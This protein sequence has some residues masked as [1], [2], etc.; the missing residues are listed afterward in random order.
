MVITKAQTKSQATCIHKKDRLTTKGFG[1]DN[2]ANAICSIC[3]TSEQKNITPFHAA[4]K[5]FHLRQKNE[6]QE[7]A[8][9]KQ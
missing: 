9:E 6:M 1:P 3:I 2:D 4:I 5:Q 7:R 8:T